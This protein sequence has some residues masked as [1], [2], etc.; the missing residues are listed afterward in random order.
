MAGGKVSSGFG[1]YSGASLPVEL[2]SLDALVD[3]SNVRLVWETASETNNAGFEIQ[4]ATVGATSRPEY[5]TLGFVPGSG[6]SNSR[7]RYTYTSEPLEPGTYS[8]RLRQIDFDG[9]SELSQSLE[10]TVFADEA[11]VVSPAYPNPILGKGEFTVTLQRE[12]DVA[13]DLYDVMGRRVRRLFGGAIP[14]HRTRT[15]ELQAATLS[16]GV[17][18][19]RVESTT[20]NA[21]RSVIVGR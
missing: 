19:I 6:N 18:F 1:I 3:G 14:A 8:F 21:T 13:V 9:S 5:S 17:Y 4:Y 16:A 7:I 12:D 2:A 15:I 20:A 10:V 11:L